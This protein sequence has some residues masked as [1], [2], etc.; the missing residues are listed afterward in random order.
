[1]NRPAVL[2]DAV[3][4]GSDEAALP[5]ANYRWPILADT[6]RSIPLF[7]GLSREDVAKIMGHL[8]EVDF[9]SGDK[10]FSQGDSGDAL[11]LIQSGAAHVQLDS[12]GGRSETIAVLGPRE[13]FGEMALLSS[14]PRSATVIA[15]KDCLLW[16]LSR[17][18]WDD[19]IAKHATWLLHF[20]AVLSQR[21]S[22]KDRQYSLGRQAFD[23][24]A[25]E[26]YS[27]QPPEAQQF[28]RHAALLTSLDPRAVGA[29]FQTDAARR[30]SRGAGSEPVA[31]DSSIDNR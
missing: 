7:S 21:L 24:L 28:Y 19:L 15:V 11:Y 10:I 27:K 31:A 26:F 12:G 9:A 6:I 16:K 20:C 4:L 13:Y 3:E 23:S 1:M 17:E 30:L 2:L 29:L 22:E 8:V 14:A 25:S 5:T 18:S